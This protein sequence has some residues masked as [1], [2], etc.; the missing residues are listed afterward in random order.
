MSARES[1]EKFREFTNQMRIDPQFSAERSTGF[2]LAARMMGDEIDRLLAALPSEPTIE[3]AFLAGFTNGM[4]A[5]A[6]RP[7][8]GNCADWLKQRSGK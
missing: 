6:G 2:Y 8:F 1:L 5:N 4:S 7:H 3:E